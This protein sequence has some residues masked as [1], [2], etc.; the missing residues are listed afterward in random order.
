MIKWIFF[1]LLFLVA[2]AT[3]PKIQDSAMA[4]IPVPSGSYSEVLEKWTDSAKNYSNFSSTFQATATFLAPEV[5]EHQ[6]YVDAKEYS[7]TEEKFRSERQNILSKAETSAIVFIDFYTEKDENN[8]LGESK[9]DWNV[10]LESDGKRVVTSSVK[11]LRDTKLQLL[12]KYPYHNHW[13]RPYLLT[14]PISSTIASGGPLL[15]IISGPAGSAR[16]NF[17]KKNN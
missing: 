15:L 3:E 8:N 6:V 10:F 17:P 7:W 2:C 14:F 13:S 1:S 9:S 12:E 11:R 16:L 5:L 4:G